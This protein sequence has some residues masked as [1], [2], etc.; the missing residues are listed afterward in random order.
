MRLTYIDRIVELEPGQRIRAIKNLS[1]SEEYLADHFPYFPVMPGVLMLEAMYQTAAWLARVTDNFEHSLVTM[2]EA[3]NV[4]Y[5]DF[6]EPGQTL[7]LLADLVQQDDHEFRFKCQGEVNNEIAVRGRL[8]L[9]L[10]RLSDERAG[11]QPVDEFM[12]ASLR[13]KFNIL[14]PQPPVQNKAV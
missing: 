2:A 7:C 12:L 13:K 1:I 10:A 3:N 14:Y 9:K 8:V 4:K 6:V 11:D 5:S